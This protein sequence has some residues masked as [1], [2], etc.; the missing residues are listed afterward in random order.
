[1]Q[2]VTL[3]KLAQLVDG[4]VVGDPDLIIEG[5]ADLED[6]G[7]EHITFL[8]NPKY[9]G[10]VKSSKAGA[11]IVSPEWK[12]LGK[13]LVVCADP[14]LAFAKI[15]TFFSREEKAP[16][17]VSQHAVLEPDVTL[18]E[19]I[20]IHPLVY[21]SSG[22]RIGDRTEI[23]PG[24]YV[25]EDVQIG[26][27]C[28]IFPNVT[29]LKGT[30]IGDRVIIHSGTVIGSDGFGYAPSPE[31]YFKI[32]Q[33]GIVQIDD[34]VEIG[35]NC[36]IDRATFGKTRIKQG[37]KIDNLV[38]IAHNVEVGEH[39]AI[40]SQV[41]ISGS[42]KIGNQVILAG[43]VG[44]AGHLTIG[45]R[46]RVGAQSGIA[47]SVPPGKDISGSPAIEHRTWLKCSAIYPRLPQMRKN[48]R[49]LEKRIEILEKKLN[50]GK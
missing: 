50:E 20:S 3:S 49:D 16:I 14:Y 34:D 6:A 43:Q 12:K 37:T 1:M 45:D 5:I 29:I 23:F 36:T 31:G 10:A 9:A 25:G 44:V 32:P 26:N 41:G 15:A 33:N 18:G 22:S 4:E 2:Q 46:V 21:I 42:T 17:G 35:A 38:Q 39:T 24:S 13:N 27:D 40:V 11:I 47:H 48:I 8:A 7:P 19:D 28:T 30:V